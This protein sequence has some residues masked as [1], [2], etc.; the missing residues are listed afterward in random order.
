MEEL[1]AAQVALA[2]VEGCEADADG[3]RSFDPVHAE[4]LVEAS[5][6]AFGPR[7]EE[8]AAG[9]RAVPVLTAQHT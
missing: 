3:D 8:E 6:D 5:L 1:E 2:D 7:D 9:H 4:A